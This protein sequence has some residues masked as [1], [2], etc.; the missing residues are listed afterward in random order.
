MR[1]RFEDL[2]GRKFGRLTVEGYMGDTRWWCKCDCGGKNIVQTGHLKSGHVRSCGCLGLE[3]SKCTKNVYHGFWNTD[4]SKGTMKFYL[5]W[6]NIKA[7]C[8]N[9][10]LKCYKNYGGRGITY[11]PRW[12]D[13]E[14]FKNDMYFEY[15][16][17]IKQLKIKH[18][19]IERV[20]VN[21]NYN[22][23]NCTFVAFRDQM[24]NSRS[25]ISFIAISP[26][27]EEFT[28]KNVN[29]F[30][31]KHNLNSSHVYECL[32]GK[33]SHHKGWKFKETTL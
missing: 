9:S 1:G 27:G 24:K 25:V 17:T 12:K 13:F 26:E 29:E 5:M 15:L 21:G 14:E 30:S 7:R 18:P 16:Y 31:D 20:D 10:N 23:E 33:A 4:Y 3:S 19:S 11:D 32:K 22:K 6:R 28:T 2:A 8:D